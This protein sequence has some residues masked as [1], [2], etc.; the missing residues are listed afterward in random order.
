MLFGPNLVLLCDFIMDVCELTFLH[1]LHVQL[2]GR[3][4]LHPDQALLHQEL[5]SGLQ[6]LQG[7]RGSLPL[8]FPLLQESHL[9]A[10]LT[11]TLLHQ[12]T[13]LH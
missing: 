3:G 2:S 1:H 12:E 5:D 11:Q 7:L 9:G 10:G 4:A 8:S 6:L 13:Q